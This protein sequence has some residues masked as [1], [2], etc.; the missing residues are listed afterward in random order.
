MKVEINGKESQI[1]EKYKTIKVPSNRF[2]VIKC[3]R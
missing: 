1:L 3:S 2:E